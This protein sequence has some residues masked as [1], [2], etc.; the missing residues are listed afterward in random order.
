MM[1][2][3]GRP[4]SSVGSNSHCRTA[5]IAALIEQRNRPQHADVGDPAVLANRDFG[6]DETLNPR[7]LRLQRIPD[8]RP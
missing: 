8:A 6:D 3:T 5:S 2:G 1:I 7:L 4:L